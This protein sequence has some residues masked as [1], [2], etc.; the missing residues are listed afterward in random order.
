MRRAW[1]G[2]VGLA[3]AG[4]R[5]VDRLLLLGRQLDRRLALAYL[6]DV[7]ARLVSVHDR[8]ENDPGAV[9]VEHRDGAGLS[10][11]H[12]PVGVVAD[13][14]VV[15]DRAVDPL[16]GGL[17]A[18]L[19]AR[20][21]LLDVLAE[22][23]EGLIELGRMGN[24]IAPAVTEHGRLRA[25]KRAQLERQ[26]DRKDERDE[27]DAAGGESDDPLRGRQIVQGGE[28]NGGAP[29]LPHKRP[30]RIWAGQA[31]TQGSGT[32]R[33]H[34]LTPRTQPG[35]GQMRQAA[36]NMAWYVCLLL[37]VFFSP[38]TGLTDTLIDT[39][40][41]VGGRLGSGTDAVAVAPA[42]IESICWSTEIAFP[43]PVMRTWTVTFFSSF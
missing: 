18:L 26:H 28:V 33:E 2:G 8:R 14:R 7:H 3:A 22:G 6:L 11:G 21:S 30:W 37:S 19:E 42:A 29:R 27:R 17:R 10:A 32:V 1:L 31:R 39:G 20:E 23:D 5:L 40:R 4:E 35:D 36:V 25:P 38:G 9:R 16:V 34:G 13:K 43:A 15:G 24:E 41:P 12:L